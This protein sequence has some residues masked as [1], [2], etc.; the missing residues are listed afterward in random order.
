VHRVEHLGAIG[1]GPVRIKSL[2]TMLEMLDQVLAL[3]KD[4]P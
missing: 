1:R 4:L 3:K 2:K